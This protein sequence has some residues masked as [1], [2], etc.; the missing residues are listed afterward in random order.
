M[1]CCLI[2]SPD[3]DTEDAALWNL[4]D[5]L[6][7]LEITF[8]FHGGRFNF[9]TLMICVLSFLYDQMVMWPRDIKKSAVLQHRFRYVRRCP[10]PSVY[11]D[12]TQ[13]IIFTRPG[14][15]WARPILEIGCRTLQGV[16]PLCIYHLER[17]HIVGVH[18]DSS[19]ASSCRMKRQVTEHIAFWFNFPNW[20]I[21]VYVYI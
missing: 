15:S 16:T 8:A 14:H 6:H 19:Q 21:Y 18:C 5:C 7:R 17:N 2:K 10:F 13:Y 12:L 3:Y 1:I 20:E 9:T 4:I 11:A